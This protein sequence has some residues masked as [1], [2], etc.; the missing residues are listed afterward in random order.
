MYIYNISYEKTNELE[1]KIFS[2][3]NRKDYLLPQLM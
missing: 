2:Y 1:K 3:K